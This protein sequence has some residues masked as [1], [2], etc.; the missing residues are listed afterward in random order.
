MKGTCANVWASD[1]TTTG[2][3]KESPVSLQ[4][5]Y[6]VDETVKVIKRKRNG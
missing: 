5:L 4:V 3:R 6:A 1:Q 2:R